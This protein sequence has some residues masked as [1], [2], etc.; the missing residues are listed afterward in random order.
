MEPGHFVKS[1]TPLPTSDKKFI[2]MARMDLG[3][4]PEQDLRRNHR[5]LNSLGFTTAF[6]P[7][8]SSLQIRAAEKPV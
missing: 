4:D 3:N 1:S 6:P 2:A 8:S 7:A 5:L